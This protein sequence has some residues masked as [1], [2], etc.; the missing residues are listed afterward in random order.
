MEYLS[1]NEWGWHSD[2]SIPYMGLWFT[3]NDHVTET[4]IKRMTKERSSDK[5]KYMG[6]VK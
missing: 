5:W 6:H 4:I 1:Q 2:G 3:K